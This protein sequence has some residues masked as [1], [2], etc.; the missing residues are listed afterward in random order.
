MPCCLV[1]VCILN[2][3]MSM[4]KLVTH[5]QACYADFRR[6]MWFCTFKLATQILGVQCGFVPAFCYLFMLFRAVRECLQLLPFSK[7]TKADTQVASVNLWLKSANTAATRIRETYGDL[8][9]SE[10]RAI[11]GYALGYALLWGP[12]MLNSSACSVAVL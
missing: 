1:L 8:G 2:A 9:L 10:V 4:A 5:I 7:A 11:T 3:Q 12:A 6:L